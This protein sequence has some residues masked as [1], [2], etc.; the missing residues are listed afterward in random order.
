MHSQSGTLARAITKDKLRFLQRPS[1]P[2]AILFFDGHT[3]SR[4]VSAI[5][6]Y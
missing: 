6:Q 4:H 2:D 5:S 3:V 1:Q